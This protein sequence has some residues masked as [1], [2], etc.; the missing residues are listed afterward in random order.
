MKYLVFSLRRL[1]GGNFLHFPPFLS[2]LT[3]GN[4]SE[5]KFPL[6]RLYFFPSS[7]TLFFCLTEGNLFFSHS[8]EKNR[9]TKGIPPPKLMLFS[10]LGHKS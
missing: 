8:R 1:T 4:F 3:G 2:C 7:E 5:K 10:Y 9:R 6:V